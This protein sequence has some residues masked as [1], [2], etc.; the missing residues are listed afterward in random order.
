VTFIGF[1]HA[2]PAAKEK[3]SCTSTSRLIRQRWP[4]P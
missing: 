3:N 2:S 4:P 1:F